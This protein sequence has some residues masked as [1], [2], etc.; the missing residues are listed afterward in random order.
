[1]DRFAAVSLIL[2]AR[3]SSGRGGRKIL[4]SSSGVARRMAVSAPVPLR[5]DHKTLLK[6]RGRKRIKASE[7]INDGAGTPAAGATEATQVDDVL[8]ASINAGLLDI[9]YIE[10]RLLKTHLAAAS[11]HFTTTIMTT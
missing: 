6:C 7:Q 4:S 10:H 2:Y 9:D 1:M 5:V 8:I 11:A 3:D